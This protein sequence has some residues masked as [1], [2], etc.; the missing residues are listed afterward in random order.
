[1]NSSLQ[2]STGIF[3]RAIGHVIMTTFVMMHKSSRS[4]IHPKG[5]QANPNNDT[6]LVVHSDLHNNMFFQFDIVESVWGYIRHV[7]SG[8]I[9][10]PKG[11]ELFPGNGTKLVLHSDRH[12]GAL[13]ALDH[14]NNYIVHKG[15][16]IRS[17]ERRTTRS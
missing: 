15:G 13:F 17:P 14:A 4:Y 12:S 2:H 8:K 7:T 16:E 10:H 3:S 9:V 11:G 1:M 6:K 5:G